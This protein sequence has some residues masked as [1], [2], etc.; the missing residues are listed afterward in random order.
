MST[1]EEVGFN[2]PLP[3]CTKDQEKEVQVS[4][5]IVLLPLMKEGY[6]TRPPAEG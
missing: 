2:D 3:C 1:S 6:W 4:R 5:N